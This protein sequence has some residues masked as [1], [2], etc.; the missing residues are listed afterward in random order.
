MLLMLDSVNGVY[1]LNLSNRIYM[2]KMVN[3]DSFEMFKTGHEEAQTI[4]KE[5][6]AE[7]VLLINAV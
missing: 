2:C 3:S 1:L 5:K 7:M 6:R 4:L